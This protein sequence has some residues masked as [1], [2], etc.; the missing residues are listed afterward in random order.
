MDQLGLECEIGNGEEAAN[1]PSTKKPF[2]IFMAVVGCVVVIPLFLF[3]VFKPARKESLS[4]VSNLNDLQ[5]E[6]NG[7]L[8]ENRGIV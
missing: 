4:Q 1:A 2:P 5:M 3:L 7:I 6:E 8:P